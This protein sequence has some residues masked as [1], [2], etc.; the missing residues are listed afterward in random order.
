VSTNLAHLL[1]QNQNVSLP[2]HYEIASPIPCSESV[3]SCAVLLC[4]SDEGYLRWTINT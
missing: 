2:A 4:F 3:P 1:I